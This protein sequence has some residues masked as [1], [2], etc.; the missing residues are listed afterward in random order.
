M[1]V[2]TVKAVL[3]SWKLGRF[4]AEL[5]MDGKAFRPDEK[6]AALLIPR[7]FGLAMINLYTYAGWGSVP[8]LERFCRQPGNAR[9]RH[10]LVRAWTTP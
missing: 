5:Y 3:N 2:G 10:F 7:A 1:D 9:E 4:D 8:L 6:T